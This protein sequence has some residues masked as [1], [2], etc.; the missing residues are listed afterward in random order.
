MKRIMIALAVLLFSFPAFAQGGKL[1]ILA[2]RSGEE[3]SESIQSYFTVLLSGEGRSE[4]LENL[5]NPRAKPETVRLAVWLAGATKPITAQ[6]YRAAVV[7][8]I[9]LYK[10]RAVLTISLPDLPGMDGDT[11]EQWALWKKGSPVKLERKVVEKILP[12]EQYFVPEQW[13]EELVLEMK[14]DLEGAM[15]W[16]REGKKKI[17]AVEDLIAEAAL[18]TA[19]I[20]SDVKRILGIKP[21]K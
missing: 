21:G 13:L 1:D 20:D 6:A 7:Q 2:V 15:V 9:V 14:G 16:Y 11:E 3:L 4:A 17:P 18:S 19:V 10:D 12:L 5:F 8:K